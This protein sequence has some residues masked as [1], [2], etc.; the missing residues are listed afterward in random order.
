[1]DMLTSLL[2]YAAALSVAVAIPGPGVAALVG[3][4]LGGGLRGALFFIGGT[5][6]GDLVYLSIAVAGL[7]ALAQLFEGAFLVIK[8]F[9]GGYLIY[10]AWRFWTHKAGLTQVDKVKERGGL[11][12]FVAGFT[13]AMGNPKVIVFYLALLPTVLD[14]DTVGPGEW[15]LLSGL[16][17]VV[18]FATLTPYAVLAS[19]ARG[20]MK[21]SDALGRLNRAAAAII[22]GAGVLILGQAAAAAVRRS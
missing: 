9:G 22:G 11:R 20:M 10:L 3:Q 2:A 1:M 7:A 4:S 18:L 13:I 5:A 15:A 14:L 16:T 17:V 8:L 6:L 12:A 21:R 19:R